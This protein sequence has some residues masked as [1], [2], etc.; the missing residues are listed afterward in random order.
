VTVRVKNAGTGRMPVEIAAVAG[1]RW[2]EDGRVSPAYKDARVTLVLAAGEQKLARI[3]CPFEPE[4][5]V[6]DPDAKVMQLQ[7]QAA[8]ARL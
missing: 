2:G 1:P 6:A 4:T 5:V 7:R 8:A 3:R